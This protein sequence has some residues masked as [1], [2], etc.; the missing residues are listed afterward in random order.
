MRRRWCVN[1]PG[2][3][4]VLS[5]THVVMMLECFGVRLVWWKEGRFPVVFVDH[6]EVNEGADAA[7]LGVDRDNS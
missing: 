4:H 1:N 5:T 7:S 3:D 2:R 6:V